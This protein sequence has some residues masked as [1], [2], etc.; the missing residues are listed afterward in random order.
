MGAL[1]LHFG[2]SSSSDFSLTRNYLTAGRLCGSVAVVLVDRTDA[3]R[4]TRVR[5]LPS[6]GLLVP[7]FLSRTG[8]Q[9]YADEK[10]QQVREYRPPEEV[11]HQDSLDTFAAAPVTIGHKVVSAKNWANLAVGSTAA[12][13]ANQRH[14]ADDNEWV[15]GDLAISRDDAIKAVA[16]RKAAGKPV[17]LSVGYTCRI[18]KSPGVTPSGEAYDQIQRGIRV[19]HIAMLLDD[20]DIPRAGAGAT[21]RLDSHGNPMKETIDGIEYEVGSETHVSAL[22]AVGARAVQRADAAEAKLTEAKAAAAKVEAERD[23]LRQ[24]AAS[25]TDEALEA[26]AVELMAFRDKARKVLGKDYSF[27]GKS[28]HQVRL[29]CLTKLNAMPSNTEETYVAA[30]LEARLDALPEEYDYN[31]PPANLQRVEDRR[32]EDGEDDIEKLVRERREAAAKAGGVL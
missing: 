12:V 21:L 29:D 19:N 22:R 2:R 13:R 23:Q 32:R 24:D 11:F 6:G 20:N 4:V 10:G 25:N 7:G 14:D 8:V 15:A 16:R 9:T 31:K 5:E 30:Y 3:V 28:R 27:A 1:R 18:D 26:R 17:S